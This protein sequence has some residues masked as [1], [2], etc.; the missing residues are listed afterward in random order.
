MFCVE[1][2]DNFNSVKKLLDPSVVGPMLSDMLF[3]RYI[4]LF[5]LFDKLLWDG[6]RFRSMVFDCLNRHF[7]IRYHFG[8]KRHSDQFKRHS[9]NVLFTVRGKEHSIRGDEQHPAICRENAWAVWFKGEYVQEKSFKE[10]ASK[11]ISDFK[12]KFFPKWRA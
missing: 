9:G 2:I 7:G 1:K 11:E 10:R 5:F 3:W 12:G 6:K 8:D 4:I